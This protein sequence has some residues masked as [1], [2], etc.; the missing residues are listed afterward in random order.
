MPQICII[1]ISFLFH[2]WL[3]EAS[4][5]CPFRWG[6]ITCFVNLIGRYIAFMLHLYDIYVS[7]MLH[8]CFIHVSFMPLKLICPFYRASPRWGLITSFRHL[9]SFMPVKLKQV[10]TDHQLHKFARK[11]RYLAKDAPWQRSNLKNGQILQLPDFH[12]EAGFIR[13]ATAFTPFPEISPVLML[14]NYT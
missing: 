3:L 10:G 7:F 12:C 4:R 13:W 14:K 8:S 1:Y 2:F 11:S 6:L 5:S 9:C